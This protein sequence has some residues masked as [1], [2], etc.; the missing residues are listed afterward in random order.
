ML[1]RR[2]QTR[3]RRGGGQGAARVRQGQDRASGAVGGARGPRAR[4]PGRG[5]RRPGRRGHQGQG[6]AG[7]DHGQGRGHRE[8]HAGRSR[9]LGTSWSTTCSRASPRRR[10]PRRRRPRPHGTTRSRTPR[11]RRPRPRP[12]CRRTSASG[13]VVASRCWPRWSRPVPP[14]AAAWKA[15]QADR[16]DPWTPAPVTE[17]T[18]IDVVPPA[19]ATAGDTLGAVVVDDKPAPL[20]EEPVADELGTSLGRATARTPRSTSTAG[21]GRRTDPAPRRLSAP[22]TGEARDRLAGWAGAGRQSRS[23]RPTSAG[24]PA[25]SPSIDRRS[26]PDPAVEA[27]QQVGRR[28]ADRRHGVRRRAPAPAAPWPR[29]TSCRMRSSSSVTV[30][31]P[32]ASVASSRTGP[33]STARAVDDPPGAEHEELV[34]GVGGDRRVEVDLA[35]GGPL[36]VP[37][38]DGGLLRLVPDD[39]RGV[40]LRRPGPA[41]ARPGR[42]PA[43]AFTSSAA[44]ARKSASSSSGSAGRPGALASSGGSV[45]LPGDDR[46]PEPLHLAQVP[47]EVGHVPARAG[48]HLRRRSCPARSVGERVAVAFDGGCVV[49][50]LDHA[51][52][53]SG[54]DR[55]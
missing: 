52:V 25:G 30:H 43:C 15:R 46:A 7:R 17:D 1:R 29:P 47:D 31:A 13:V 28:A 16:Q 14:A 50:L 9:P 41:V 21:A 55:P 40:L 10:S 22:P 20:A 49:G 36:G 44:P 35:A 12:T 6:G 27:E 45:E 42:R 19:G 2:K 39:E 37:A 26:G 11:R 18:R 23:L 33:G 8:G 32:P 51:D 4:H 34:D 5:A 54:A 3:T 38:V 24:Q 53:P 48:H